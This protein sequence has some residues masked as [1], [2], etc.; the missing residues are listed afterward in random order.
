[1][2]EEESLQLQRL[3][4]NVR[5]LVGIISRQ[6]ETLKKLREDLRLRDEEVAQLR[7]QLQMAHEQG[8]THSLA[9]ALA[10]QASSTS[11]S[12]ARAL[13]D[14]IISDVDRCIRQLSAE[15]A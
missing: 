8:A 9:S 11:A 6:G 10:G 7:S 4:V 2:T 13:L 12:Q 5:R 15:E 1:M 3:E 14:E